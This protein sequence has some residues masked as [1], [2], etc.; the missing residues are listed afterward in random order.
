[1]T[2]FTVLF[3]PCHR[4][5]MSIRGAGMTGDM[6]YCTGMTGDMLYCTNLL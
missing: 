1:M 6:L 3:L 2:C 4:V 5:E